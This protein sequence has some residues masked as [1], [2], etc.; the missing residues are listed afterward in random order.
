MHALA[1]LAAW[2]TRVSA[3]WVPGAFTIAALLT[4]LVF[5]L[6]TTVG[7]ASPAEAARAWGDG[8]WV[9][10]TFGMQMSLIVFCGYLVAVSPAAR[11]LLRR[12]AAIPRTPRGSVALVAVVSMVASWIHWGMGLITAAV[13]TGYVAERERGADFRLLVAAAYLGLGATWH[14]G[15]SGS[16]PLLLATPDNFLVKQGLL[17]HTIPL[18]R[19]VLTAPNLAMVAL[20]IVVLTAL[21]AAMHPEPAD[22]VVLSAADARKLVEVPEA[23]ARQPTPASRLEHAPFA[24]LV[25]G[26]AGLAFL[27]MRV[28]DKGAAA[29]LNLDTLNLGFLS[30]AVLLHWTPA[31]LGAA[32]RRA[33]EPLHGIVLQFPLY[34]GMFG[35]I[36]GTALAERAAALLT[37]VS[38]PHTYP[39]V[40][41]W[42]SAVLNYFVPSGGS[43]WAIEAPYVLEAAARLHVPVESVAMA[44]AF[45]DMGTNLIQPFWA[46]PL[47]AV[48]RIEFR[49]VLGYL[50]VFFLAYMALASA[51]VLAIA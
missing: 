26:G 2:F 19:T 22:A 20:V 48:A 17:D 23:P 13:L 34:A 49:A 10:L 41:C 38:T 42:Y 47:L 39:L 33:A 18:G 6:G 11:W 32:V 36:K 37:S 45:G 16:V 12:V 29:A 44:Y 8:L 27:A 51:W 5:A 31:S 46:I 43:K 7:G 4:A 21:A 3:R 14:A 24:N 25:V 50:V 35:V 28:A 1:R 40:V 9:L 15:L 30:L